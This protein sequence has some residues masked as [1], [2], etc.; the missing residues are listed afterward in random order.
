MSDKFTGSKL[1][2][3]QGDSDVRKDVTICTND[4]Y[5]EQG[6]TKGTI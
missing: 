5:E 4:V 3:E 2:D 1:D 6:R